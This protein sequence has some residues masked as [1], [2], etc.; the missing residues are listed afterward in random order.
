MHLSQLVSAMAIT[1]TANFA[2]E[3]LHKDFKVLR[4]LS[5]TAGEWAGMGVLAILVW[6]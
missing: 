4:F 2:I 3:L 6:A 1:I 5:L